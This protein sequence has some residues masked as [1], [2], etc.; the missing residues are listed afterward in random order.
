[1]E[2]QKK[3]VLLLGL[4]HMKGREDIAMHEFR[5]GDS[6]LTLTHREEG[7]DEEFLKTTLHRH[8][9]YELAFVYGGRATQ[10]LGATPLEMRRG[11]VC[12]RTPHD[13]HS[14][15]QSADEPLMVYTI[16]FSE[17]MIVKG[18]FHELRM[19]ERTAQVYYTDEEL[20]EAIGTVKRV[21]NELKRR[22][23]HTR[24]VLRSLLAELLVALIRKK[25]T[26]REK[27]ISE[28]AHI[29][30]TVRY[31][32]GH[33]KESLRL[34]DLAH[35]LYLT[36][37]YLGSL[38]IKHMGKSCSEYIMELRFSFAL[39]LLL[40][41]DLTVKEITEEC[42]FR[43]SSYFIRKFREK[44]GVSPHRYRTMQMG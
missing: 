26:A 28:S 9:F 17:D 34:C 36:P 37:N 32:N 44:Y 41:S 13:L 12:L 15:L 7:L 25:A 5:E 23:G 33:F 39:S 18:V 31:I 42:G 4:N 11:Y 19:E 14:V 8:E 43:S 40:N 24:T 3:R 22:D 20:A 1:M 21:E 2:K 30:K 29:E 35:R 16:S 38:F 10:I 6:M 27:P